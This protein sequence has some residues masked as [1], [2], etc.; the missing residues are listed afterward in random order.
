MPWNQFNLWYFQW[1]VRPLHSPSLSHGGVRSERAL[2]HKV[3][4]CLPAS[5]QC[6][7]GGALSPVK[8]VKV[9]RG[10]GANPVGIDRARARGPGTC[11]VLGVEAVGQLPWWH[12]CTVGLWVQPQFVCSH[13]Y[14]SLV[15]CFVCE[16]SLLV[17]WVALPALVTPLPSQRNASSAA[18][19]SSLLRRAPLS[20][21][22]SLSVRGSRRTRC[23]PSSWLHGSIRSLPTPSGAPQ[24]GLACSGAALHLCSPWLQGGTHSVLG[25]GEGRVWGV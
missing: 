6:H 13:G 21:A 16:D 24:A 4:V 5:R 7:W 2:P 12:A 3:T 19:H 23:T 14:A 25:R 1:T 15:S 8:A 17:P 18:L 20:R 11:C 10:S 22:P 9:A